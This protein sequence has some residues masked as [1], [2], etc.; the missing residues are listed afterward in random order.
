MTLMVTMSGGVHS[1]LL[2]LVKQISRIFIVYQIY[3]LIVAKFRKQTKLLHPCNVNYCNVMNVNHAFLLDIA[4][5]AN[6]LSISCQYLVVQFLRKKNLCFDRSLLCFVSLY[7]PRSS[8]VLVAYNKI[9]IPCLFLFNIE[10]IH[11]R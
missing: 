11:P 10:I 7:L 6:K 1:Q 2:Y 3:L 4:S 5:I 8:L 9:N